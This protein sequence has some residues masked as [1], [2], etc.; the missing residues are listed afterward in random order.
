[1]SRAT[2]D[3]PLR[4]RKK[5]QT[6]QALADAAK[7]CF[8]E[9]GF[10]ATTMTEV[11]RAAGVSEQTV[12]N[13]YPTKES[14]VFDREE[15]IREQIVAFADDAR[16]LISATRSFCYG[17]IERMSAVA[18]GMAGGMVALIAAHPRLRGEYLLRMEHN[19][20]ALAEALAKRSKAPLAAERIRAASVVAVFGLL[21][22]E[23]GKAYVQGRPL[24]KAL[25][26]A[27]VIVDTA[28]DA[29]AR[30]VR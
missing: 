25:A 19:A 5:A 7:R 18:D 28:L 30:G 21:V 16:G 12:Y 24:K 10:D 13:Y 17:M 8:A 27:R 23:V 22:D 14:L 11:A 2:E 3:L 20:D 4:A 1:M 15:E 9:N 26:N 6:R 29:L